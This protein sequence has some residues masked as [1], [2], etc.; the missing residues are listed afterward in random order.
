MFSNID[1]SYAISTRIIKE[2]EFMQVPISTNIINVAY[3]PQEYKQF[4][5]HRSLL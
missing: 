4:I 2:S 1:K 3:G 5:E